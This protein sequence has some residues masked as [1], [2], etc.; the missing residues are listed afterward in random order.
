M[1]VHQIFA[2]LLIALFL[3][4][5]IVRLIQKDRLDIAYS[6]LWLAIGIII[7]LVVMKYEWLLLLTSW[8]GAVIPTTTL[9]IL[10]FMVVLLMCLQFSI[11]ISRQRRQIK[12]LTQKIAIFEQKMSEHMS[13]SINHEVSKDKQPK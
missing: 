8:L 13:A 2:S 1:T 6:W 5:L 11:V 7:T 12:R 9:F 10:G 3:L 4:F